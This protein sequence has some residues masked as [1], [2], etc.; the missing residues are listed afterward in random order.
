MIVALRNLLVALVLLVPALAAAGSG[1]WRV[2]KATDQVT[3]SLD[4]KTWRPVTA[5]A[6]IPNNAW[7]ATGPRAR[8]T[9]ARGVERISFQPDTEIAIIT[10]DF[11]VMR[12]TEVLQ[13]RGSIELEIEKRLLPHTSVKTPYLAAIVKGT[14]FRVT[15]GPAGAE[16]AVRGGLVEV[17][18]FGSGE[19]A[20]VGAGQSASA[21]ASAMSVA[22]TTSRPTI[23][24]APAWSVKS[25]AASASE[26]GGTVEA[27]AATS[28]SGATGNKG[29]SQ[30]AASAG[31]NAS[32]N[33]SSNSNAGGNSSGSNAGGNSGGSNAGGNSGSSNAG[34]NSGNSNAGGNSGNS[35]AGGKGKGNSGN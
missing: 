22:G 11:V 29:Q 18:S 35:N 10:H 27:M 20:R 6:T 3:Y 33:A 2:E 25:L 24:K 26:L 32:S 1:E 15:V 16:V 23:G 17:I 14:V 12:K 28:G 9:L 21:N 31:S 34:G 7:V 8:A 13:Q 4:R 5:G 19:R 30:A